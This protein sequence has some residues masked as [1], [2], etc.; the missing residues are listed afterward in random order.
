M[1]TFTVQFPDGAKYDVD[2]PEG[3]TDVQAYEYA[4]SH[5]T[6]LPDPITRQS[7]FGEEVK[8]GVART[9]E[10]KRLGIEQLLGDD[11]NQPLLESMAR[12][13]ETAEGLGI[14][15]SL[16]R[17][18]D[19][20]QTEGYGAAAAELPSD[21]A[22]YGGQQVGILGTLG[23]GA[24]LASWLMPGGAALKGLAGVAGGVGALTPDY[25]AASMERLA[26]EQMAR[27]EEV[28]VDVGEAYKYA[29]MQAALEAG[30]TALFLG[31][32]LLRA[33]TGL[34]RSSGSNST[35]T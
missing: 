16:A 32:N 6:S 35:A 10:A 7:T 18:Q 17:I 21:I 11:P 8:R 4:V 26:Q 29:A 1:P 25:T 20:A 22:R 3:T 15:P 30:G 13:Q 24:R 19:I 27:G 12:G 14:P 5:L 34:G 31:K 23:T 2:A 33:I 9:L 28:D